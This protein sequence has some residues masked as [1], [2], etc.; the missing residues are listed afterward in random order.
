MRGLWLSSPN[1]GDEDVIVRE[2]P[3]TL[4]NQNYCKE[5]SDFR[6]NLRDTWPGVFAAF[7]IKCG[8]RMQ[9]Q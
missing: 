9:Y 2:I 1:L 7:N 8:V 5:Y 3:D 6:N 4:D